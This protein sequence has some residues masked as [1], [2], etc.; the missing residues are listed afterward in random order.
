M[1]LIPNPENFLIGA[2]IG[3]F[4]IA[5]YELTNKFLRKYLKNR[6]NKNDET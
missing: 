4:A 3:M 5:A 6:R 2:I 1:S